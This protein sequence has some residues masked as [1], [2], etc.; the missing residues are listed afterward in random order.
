MTS[1]VGEESWA[2]R[3]LSP[4]KDFPERPSPSSLQPLTQAGQHHV[5]GVGEEALSLCMC[6]L[7]RTSL[8]GCGE[9][10]W[11]AGWVDIH[12]LSWTVGGGNSECQLSVAFP[13]ARMLCAKSF[14]A[15]VSKTPPNTFCT[16]ECRRTQPL[17]Q[18]SPISPCYCVLSPPAPQL[19]HW[20][21]HYCFSS[22]LV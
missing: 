8:W 22:G 9:T 17:P 18:N 16:L 21:S 10:E 7:A 19:L 2:S 14:K 4:C 15:T 13:G 3:M 20:S 6:V 5:K 1:L 12:S 11:H